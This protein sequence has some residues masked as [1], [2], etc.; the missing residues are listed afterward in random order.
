MR[1]WVLAAVAVVAL[2]GCKAKDEA[3][4]ASSTSAMQSSAAAPAATAG[5]N[6]EPGTYAVTDAKGVKST[7]MIMADGTYMDAD[8]SG[9][10]TAKGKWTSPASMQTCFTPDSG[11]KVCYT[12]SQKAADGT[13][14]ATP[15]DNSGTVTVKKTA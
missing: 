12:E 5:S 13:F 9:K 11:K 15:D 6:A 3:P 4:A 8:A 14:T 1:A 10:T 7:T 2:A